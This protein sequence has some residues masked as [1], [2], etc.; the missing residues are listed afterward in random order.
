MQQVGHELD[1]LSGETTPDGHVGCISVG[2]IGVPTQANGRLLISGKLS[3]AA[4][5]RF[6]K[7]C[8]LSQSKQAE[9]NAKT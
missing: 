2:I 8:T 5:I 4:S 1:L 3:K 6:E 7:P 9:S